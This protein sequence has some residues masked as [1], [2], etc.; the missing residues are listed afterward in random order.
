MQSD[1]ESADTTPTIITKQ[2]GN[3]SVVIGPYAHNNLLTTIG[4]PNLFI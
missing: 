3:S 4:F 1:T 2:I